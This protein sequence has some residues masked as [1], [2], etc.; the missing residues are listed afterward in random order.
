MNFVK[1]KE[2]RALPGCDAAIE[3]EFRTR[4]ERGLVR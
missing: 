4:H 3:H 1:E 2:S